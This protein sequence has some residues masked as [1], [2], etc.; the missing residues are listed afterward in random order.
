[1]NISKSFYAKMASSIGLIL[2]LRYKESLIAFRG[3]L[4]R[5]KKL[6][7]VSFWNGEVL[8]CCRWWMAKHCGFI[9]HHGGRSLRVYPTIRW[10][11]PRE[12]IGGCLC[13]FWVVCGWVFLCSSDYVVIGVFCWFFIHVVFFF[14]VQVGLWDMSCILSYVHWL[15]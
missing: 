7:L 10:V 2:F 1:M 13:W 3:P 8:W 15:N 9:R 4:T 5:V 12:E 6:E 11:M 14:V